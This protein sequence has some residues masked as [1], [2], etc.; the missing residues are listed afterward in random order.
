[1]LLIDHIAEPPD[2]V[3]SCSWHSLVAARLTSE[4]AYS[5]NHY[6][7]FLNGYKRCVVHAQC[8]PSY[9]L[10]SLSCA[11]LLQLCVLYLLT[12]HVLC[13]ARLRCR[14]GVDQA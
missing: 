12:V 8:F 4:R 5:Q 14:D 2:T 10:V 1:M 3:R 11:V 9:Q 7:H 6:G 13:A